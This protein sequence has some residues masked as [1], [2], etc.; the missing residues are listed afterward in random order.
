MPLPEAEALRE[1]VVVWEAV[2]RF[3]ASCAAAV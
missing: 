2:A 1:E 3:K